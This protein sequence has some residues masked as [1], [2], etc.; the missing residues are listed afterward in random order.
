MCLRQF[1]ISR[2]NKISTTSLQHY[3]A[4]TVKLTTFSKCSYL[5]TIQFG[6]FHGLSTK[7][8]TE[9]PSELIKTISK[10]L[11]CKEIDVLN[12]YNVEP[13]LKERGIAT[14]KQ[15]VDYL[16]ENQV[17]PTSITEYPFLLVNRKCTI[18][19]RIL[20]D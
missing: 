13:L 11:S 10:L 20:Y 16:I 19:N 6:F 18:R 4:R 12:I 9:S 7:T 15:R 17:T 1:S 8:T 3:L 14:I 5:K 2:L